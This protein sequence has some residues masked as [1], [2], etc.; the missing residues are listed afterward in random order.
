V[1]FD[2]AFA[3][4]VSPAVEGEFSDD[5][6]DRGNWTSGV[7]GQ[8]ELKGTKFGISAMSYPE[9]DIRNLTIGQAREI[10]ERDFWRLARCHEM[11]PEVALAVFDAAINQGVGSAIRMLQIA[12]N[13]DSDGVIGP[14][15][16]AAIRSR[17][18]RKLLID[19]TA[20][21]LMR[22]VDSATWNK[23]GRGWTRRAVRTA[24]EALG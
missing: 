5:P 21:R 18:S 9:L 2:R 10:Y 6:D 16:L 13:V 4:V 8:G 12:L 14:K 3:Y 7:I 22:Y 24:L 19:F 1:S 17:S 15:T 20:E 11:P 23:H